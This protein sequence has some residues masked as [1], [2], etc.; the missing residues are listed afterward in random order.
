M[1]NRFK[2]VSIDGADVCVSHYPARPGDDILVRYQWRPRDMAS[3]PESIDQFMM[4]SFDD[5]VMTDDISA[6]CSELSEESW[7]M[8][9]DPDVVADR[10]KSAMQSVIEQMKESHTIWDSPD[11]PSFG[12]IHEPSPTIH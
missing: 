11:A 3:C 6:L 8:L 7:E 12:F 1:P 2:V 10:V 4:V 5:S 9:T